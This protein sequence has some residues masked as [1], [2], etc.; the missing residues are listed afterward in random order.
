MDIC[1]WLQS[2]LINK[3][4]AKQLTAKWETGYRPGFHVQVQSERSNIVTTDFQI[5]P[6]HS[7]YLS[8]W[9]LICGRGLSTWS[10]AH[11]L[12]HKQICVVPRRSSIP[13]QAAVWGLL[14]TRLPFKV[15]M[16]F[17]PRISSLFRYWKRSQ[18]LCTYLHWFCYL[19]WIIEPLWASDLFM[20]W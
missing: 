12:R 18:S 4:E 14:W 11:H 10:A 19:V 20:K 7:F 15:S 17:S 3:H 2:S 5:C 6:L 9:L 13:G 16:I 1:S 8:N